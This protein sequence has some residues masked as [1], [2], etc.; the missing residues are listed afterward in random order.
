MQAGT[1]V[2]HYA[3]DSATR[4]KLGDAG[5]VHQD[6]PASMCGYGMQVALQS[7]QFLGR[8]TTD[9]VRPSRH[10]AI[11]YLHLA[12]TINLFQ[13]REVRA[14]GRI[15]LP[16]GSECGA[17]ALVPCECMSMR[18]CAGSKRVAEPAIIQSPGK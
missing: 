5:H 11:L 13:P 10:I 17:R 8:R 16:Q 4:I 9:E 14:R 18:R 3:L 15:Q 7:D 2:A 6:S 12:G 1:K